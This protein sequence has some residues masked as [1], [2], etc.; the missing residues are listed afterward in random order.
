MSY[1][2]TVEVRTLWAANKV[3]NILSAIK[4]LGDW[5]ASRWVVT[6]WDGDGNDKIQSVSSSVEMEAIFDEGW[7]DG[8]VV[9]IWNSKVQRTSF[10]ELGK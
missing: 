6:D 10:S 3:F 4:K 9:G 7:C 1:T 8:S 2:I 5:G